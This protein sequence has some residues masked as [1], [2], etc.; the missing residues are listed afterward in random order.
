MSLV[1]LV[2]VLVAL[3]LL[4]TGGAGRNAPGSG[5]E[6]ALLARCAGDQVQAERLVQAELRRAPSLSRGQAVARAIA[7]LPREQ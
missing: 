7:R 1:L 6:Q 5:D 3:V 4:F 2:V